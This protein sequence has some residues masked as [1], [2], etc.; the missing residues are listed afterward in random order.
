MILHLKADVVRQVDKK[1]LL[2]IPSPS[3]RHGLKQ[4][5]LLF[6]WLAQT[7]DSKPKQTQWT[8]YELLPA[9]QESF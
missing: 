4:H 1:Y 3:K 7:A 6:I 8:G 2:S 5:Q 9:Q